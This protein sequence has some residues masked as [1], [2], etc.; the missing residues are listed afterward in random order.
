MTGFQIADAT[1]DQVQAYAAGYQDAL[2]DATDRCR[3]NATA[4]ADLEQQ[5]AEARTDAAYWERV[6]NPIR[7]DVGP[8]HEQL[9]QQRREQQLAAATTTTNSWAGIAVATPGAVSEYE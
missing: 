4:I 5:L 9:E 3:R 8:S 7:V 1:I 2:A 6:A